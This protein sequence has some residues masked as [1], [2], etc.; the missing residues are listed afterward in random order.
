MKARL[1]SVA[2]VAV[3]A[4]LG[5]GVGLKVS[6]TPIPADSPVLADR[7]AAEAQLAAARSVFQG[8]PKGKEDLELVFTLPDVRFLHTW[9]LRILAL[10]VELSSNHAEQ[11]AAY[12]G[13]FKRMVDMEKLIH[14]L[15]G[16]RPPVLASFKP[17]LENYRV[18]AERRLARAKSK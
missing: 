12:Q 6:S 18:D 9:S 10:E 15:W 5:L 11:L 8:Y 16:F 2:L 17:V 14:R 3:V 1:T 4:G 7:R 13:H